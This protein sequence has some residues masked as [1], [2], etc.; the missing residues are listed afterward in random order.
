MLLECVMTFRLLLFSVCVFVVFALSL[1]FSATLSFLFLCLFLC[2]QPW[3]FHC[4]W[5]IDWSL[6]STFLAV[7]TMSHI[8]KTLFS[9]TFSVL[10]T[11][12]IKSSVSWTIQPP[13]CRWTVLPP[14]THPRA[15]SSLFAFP[16]IAYVCGPASDLCSLYLPPDLYLMSG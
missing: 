15:F 6:H 14:Q 13:V 5:Q 2:L 12:E 1:S 16:G 3:C 9:N 7:M 10:T 8:Y 4:I 11:L